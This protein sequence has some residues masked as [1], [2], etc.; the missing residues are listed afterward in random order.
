M[1][2]RRLKESGF[3]LESYSVPYTHSVCDT[4]GISKNVPLPERLYMRLR[5]CVLDVDLFVGAPFQRNQPDEAWIEARDSGA[6]PPE[7][8]GLYQA[9]GFLSFRA[10]SRF[11]TDDQNVLFSYFSMILTCL[12]DG[13]VDANG[14]LADFA[15][16]QDLTYDYGKKVR[17]EPWDPGAD[18]RARRHLRDFLLALDGSLDTLADIIA[19]FL[20]GSIAGLR[21]GRGEFATIERW[22][23][24]PLKSSSPIP[25]P[26]DSHLQKLYGALKPLIFSRPSEEDWLPLMHMLR[27]KS[28]HLGQATL[29]QMG[30]HD[31]RGRFYVFLPRIWPFIWERDFK[32]HDPSVKVDMP[33]LLT[34]LLIGQDILSFTDGLHKKVME[35]IQA[36]ISEVLSMYRAFENFETNQAAIRELDRSTVTFR[37][38]N[39]AKSTT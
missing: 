5:D 14:R 39:F 9:A 16:D 13:L 2:E 37:F 22:I 4:R 1:H 26:Y 23:A 27:N 11:L 6:I 3:I 15:K 21:L 24:Q 29:R 31:T 18:L 17:G 36:A 33:N 25:T 20:T 32:P 30:L 34:S 19:M 28:I 7:L 8:F 12:M 38:E 35:V 10:G